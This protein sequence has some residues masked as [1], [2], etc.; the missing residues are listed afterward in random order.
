MVECKLRRSYK[1][2]QK[3]LNDGP[4]KYG[5][6]LPIMF[7]DLKGYGK[8]RWVVAT[9]IDLDYE[10]EREKC[11]SDESL[12]ERCIEF[13]NTPPKSKYGKRRKRKPEYGRFESKPYRFYIKENESGE[14]YIDALLVTDNIKHSKFWD[15][16]PV[17]YG[18]KK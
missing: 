16:G 5:S 3:K 18:T 1:K 14:K 7:Y 12:V 15:K 4:P 11:D 10:N 8:N 2:Y 17:V 6:F 9:K 13:L